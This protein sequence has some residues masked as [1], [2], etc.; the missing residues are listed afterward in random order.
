MVVISLSENV[1]DLG[2]TQIPLFKKLVYLFESVG[3]VSVLV[4]Q[5]VYERLLFLNLSSISELKISFYYLVLFFVSL[6]LDFVGV[7]L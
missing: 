5:M 4:G 2:I 3:A 1:F 6:F 7:S